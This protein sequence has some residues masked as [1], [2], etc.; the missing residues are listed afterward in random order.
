MELE[1]PTNFGG[2]RR[3]TTR[4]ERETLRA[5]PYCL[6]ALRPRTAADLATRIDWK[7]EKGYLIDYILVHSRAQ[8]GGSTTSAAPVRVSTDHLPV[9]KRIRWPCDDHGARRR[10][11]RTVAWTSEWSEAADEVLQR[12]AHV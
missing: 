1:P 12:R 3:E 11:R 9:T 6:R 7:S 5:W 4:R 10:T 2:W 8:S